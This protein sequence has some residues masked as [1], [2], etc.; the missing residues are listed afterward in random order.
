M[1][2]FDVS[3]VFV[4]IFLCLWRCKWGFSCISFVQR[5]F[6][7]SIGSTYFGV[8]SR[9][10]I[11]LFNMEVF[12]FDLFTF[13]NLQCFNSSLTHIYSITYSSNSTILTHC[14]IDESR[15]IPQFSEHHNFDWF[16]IILCAYS[17]DIE[18]CFSTIKGDERANSAKNC[19]VI[20]MG[21]DK[22]V[23]IFGILFAIII[24]SFNFHMSYIPII[25][26]GLYIYRNSVPFLNYLFL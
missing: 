12:D 19:K 9:D 2:H 22:C 7:W 5:K 6:N 1:R 25:F 23:R 4:Y 8:R 10:Y 24:S 21:D 13:N 3:R 14:A 18:L 15:R 16:H 11:Y 17:I 20:V 26:Y